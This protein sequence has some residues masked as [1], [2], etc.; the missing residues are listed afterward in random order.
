MIASLN[1]IHLKAS[2]IQR[3]NEKQRK[4]VRQLRQQ[5]KELVK[6]LKELKSTSL[7]N[8]V[9]SIITADNEDEL[10][11]ESDEGNYFINIRCCPCTAI[12]I[13]KQG[14]LAIS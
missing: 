3:D 12:N 8:T 6:A 14:R 7:S 13:W 2:E 4:V 9:L 10:E 5:Q 11:E 1:G